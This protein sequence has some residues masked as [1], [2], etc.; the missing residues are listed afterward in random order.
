MHKDAKGRYLPSYYEAYQ[1]WRHLMDLR[2]S[3]STVIWLIGRR[4]LPAGNARH[5][6]AVCIQLLRFIYAKQHVGFIQ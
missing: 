3:A 1:K 4:L 6:A 2:A 5:M